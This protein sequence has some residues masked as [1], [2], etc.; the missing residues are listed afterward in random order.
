MDMQQLVDDMNSAQQS[1]RKES[2]QFTLCDLIER[3]EQ[4]PQD[5]LIP[6]GVEAMSYRGYY[7]D[8]AFSPLLNTSF[9][10][11]HVLRTAERTVDKVLTGYK[12]GDFK[13]DLDTPVWIAHYG[14]CG[15]KITGITDDGQILSKDDD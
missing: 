6:L 15:R 1:M 12:G 9:T 3:L 5:L 10:V 4:L 2:E 13:M 14:S 8:V 11:A 7:C